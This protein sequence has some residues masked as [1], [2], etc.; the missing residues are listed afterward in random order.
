MLE[1]N[2]ANRLWTLS[3]NRT[4]PSKLNALEQQ[5]GL[6]NVYIGG[7]GANGKSLNRSYIADGFIE[8]KC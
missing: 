2:Y 6:R 7:R 5:Y 8:E 4:I 3:I 1:R